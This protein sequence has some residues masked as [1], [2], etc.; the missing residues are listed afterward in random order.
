MPCVLIRPCVT[1]DAS[2]TRLSRS[3]GVGS[4]RHVMRSLRFTAY[5]LGASVLSMIAWVAT[6]PVAA[7]AEGDWY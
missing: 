6:S 5:T 2:L 1:V 3:A 4:R 7:F